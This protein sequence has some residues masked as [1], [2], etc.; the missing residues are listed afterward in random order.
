[1]TVVFVEGNGTDTVKSF[2]YG[3]A[4]TN[5]KVDFMAADLK[6]ASI[7]KSGNMKVELNSG[8]NLVLESANNQVV[9]AQFYGEEM[10]VELGDNLQYD[11][12]V[13]LY[14]A[15]NNGNKLTVGSS[16]TDSTVSIALNNLNEAGVQYNDVTEIDASSYSGTASLVGSDWTDNTIRGGAGS[17]SL[18]GGLGGD[19]QLVGGSGQNRFF[20]LMG[21]G[22]DTISHANSGDVVELLNVDIS[23]I[24]LDGTISESS[25]SAISVK[26]NNG[27]T[28]KIQGSTQSDL[29]GVG[30]KIGS[31][32]WKRNSSGQWSK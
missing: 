6:G 1:M 9:K 30:I 19:G 31:D 23:D 21:D 3:A 2:D 32:T 5:D 15:V 14:G 20:Y 16:V 25:N 12:D 26:F 27:E 8:D 28:L 29:A 18:W 24:D 17:N 10:V 13:Q 4:D 22:N 11:A 7:D